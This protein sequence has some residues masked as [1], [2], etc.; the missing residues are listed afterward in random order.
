MAL[1]EKHRNTMYN[2]FR[3]ILGEEATQAMLSQFPARDLDEPTTKADLQLVRA[4]LEI[5][6]AELRVEIAQLGDRLTARMLT[7]AGVQ[8]ALIGTL[9]A[10]LR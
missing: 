2:E 6:R 9:M 3:K 5:F 10:I 4:D 8:V 1:L 7:I